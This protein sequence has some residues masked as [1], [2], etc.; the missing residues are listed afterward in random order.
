MSEKDDLRWATVDDNVDLECCVDDDAYGSEL[1]RVV[2]NR[3][4][5]QLQTPPDGQDMIDWDTQTPPA[6]SPPPATT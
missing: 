1:D 6:S 2:R 5:I 3:S 4:A